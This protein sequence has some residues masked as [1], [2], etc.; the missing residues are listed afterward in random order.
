MLGQAPRAMEI[1]CCEELIYLCNPLFSPAMGNLF[2]FPQC[3]PSVLPH[4]PN[5]EGLFQHPSVAPLTHHT[6]QTHLI[7]SVLFYMV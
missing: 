1:A 3:S 6:S 2:N 4:P 5:L 7:I